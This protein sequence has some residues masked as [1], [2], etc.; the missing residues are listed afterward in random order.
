[1]RKNNL[2]SEE[3]VLANTMSHYFTS[4]TKL[5]LKKSPQSKHLQDIVNYYHNSIKK[6]VPH[7][8]RSLNHLLSSDD[9]KQEILMINN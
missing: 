6:N 9:I 8:T 2:N 3:S 7:I 4:I 5:C 1:M